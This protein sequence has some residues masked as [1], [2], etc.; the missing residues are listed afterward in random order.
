MGRKKPTAI[1]LL[2][3]DEEVEPRTKKRAAASKAEPKATK[4]P[5]NQLVFKQVPDNTRSIL[6]FTSSQ[7]S[8][9]QPSSQPSSAA[10]AFRQRVHSPVAVE[11]AGSVSGPDVD[12]GLWV[13][14]HAPQTREQLVVHKDK[15]AAVEA[16]LHKQAASQHAQHASCCLLITGPSGCG[17]ST[18]VHV[19]AHAAGYVVAE[20]CAPLPTLWHEHRYQADLGVP[21]ASKMDSFDD[22]VTHAKMSA[23]QLGPTA[24]AG[25]ALSQNGDASTASTLDLLPKV[26]QPATERSLVL[27]DDLPH[28][29]GAVQRKRLVQA[30]GTLAATAQQP[31]IVILTETGS[32]GSSSDKSSIP[33]TAASPGQSN[34]AYSLYADIKAAIVRAGAAHIQ[35]NPI[36]DSFATKALLALADKERL[37]LSKEAAKAL[38]V[39]SAGDLFHAI[40]TL[41]L[42]CAGKERRAAD[43]NPKKRSRGKG[44]KKAQQLPELSSTDLLGSNSRDVT[45]T[46][47]RALGK[48]LYNK[49]LTPGSLPAEQ[50]SADQAQALLALSTDKLDTSRR[51]DIQD[52]LKRAL[53][54]Y[55]A[56]AVVMHSGLEATTVSAFLHENMLHFFRDEAVDEAAAAYDFLA[57]S[58]RIQSGQH[59]SAANAWD[60][61]DHPS[62]SFA[63][64]AAGSLTARG[65]MW[66]NAHPAPRSWFQMRGPAWKAANRAR[67]SNTDAL[68]RLAWQHGAGG[69]VAEWSAGTLPFLRS[70]AAWDQTHFAARHLPARWWRLWNGQLHEEHNHTAAAEGLELGNSEAGAVVA[71][72][73]LHSSDARIDMDEIE[74]D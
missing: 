51:L 45:L 61:D 2:S 30:L 52:R 71:G 63:E 9:S 62:S 16:W 44:S 72:A 73:A 14:R 17:K 11:F 8:S 66:A 15:V 59:A 25:D 49:R 4:V 58:D 28:A 1:S 12:A 36:A 37:P 32:S 22:F 29:Q 46:M 56:E 40:E 31:V 65:F 13:E 55:N 33:G 23:L 69:S 53:S 26:S 48:I 20:W 67:L 10:D 54:E 24:P 68:S 50:P 64:A 41:Q 70:M 47:F 60:Q 39:Q 57:D 38:A 19:L 35:F 42:A 34:S 5:G 43:A 7:P 3:S 21:Y 27:V 74:D 6:A 18:T